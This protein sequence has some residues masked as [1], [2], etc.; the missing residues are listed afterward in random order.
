MKYIFLYSLISTISFT[1]LS[2]QQNHFLY[3]QTEAQQ[4]FYIKLNDKIFNSSSSGYLIVP[5]LKDG[6]YKIIFGFPQNKWPEQT[7]N[8]TLEKDAGFLIKNFSDKGWG[9]FDIQSMN[10][11]MAGNQITNT[12]GNNEKSKTDDFSEMLA[13][14][15]ND[16]T[17]KQ[18]DIAVKEQV[19]E[20]S[21]EKI[22]ENIAPVV[23]VKDTNLQAAPEVQSLYSAIVKN[24][25]VKSTDGIEMIYFDEYNNSKDTITVFIP[26]VIDKEKNESKQEEALGINNSDTSDTNNNIQPET[27]PVKLSNEADTLITAQVQ[28]AQEQLPQ[29]GELTNK[30]KTDTPTIESKEDKIEF[31]PASAG[32][33]NSNCNQYATE[34]DF[35][36]LRKKMVAEKNDDDMI[37]AAKKFFKAKCFTTKSIKNLSTLFLSDEGKYNFFD[38]AYPYVSDSDIYHTLENQL[39]EEYYIKRFKVMIHQ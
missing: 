37:R 13:T 4:P 23:P 27:Q 6:S 28:R 10:V 21:K 18:K 14:V 35:L 31:L 3:F 9:L 38:A 24:L 12:A 15:V 32:V 20:T 17:I 30:P 26:V 19:K 33:I 7:V 36:K 29:S 39:S 22:A 34:D 11:I 8:Y 25:Q 16:S 2:A 1:S 5:K